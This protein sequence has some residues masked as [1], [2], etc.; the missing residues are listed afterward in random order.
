[1]SEPDADSSVEKALAGGALQHI[2]W[3]RF[4]FGDERWEWLDEVAVLHGTRDVVVI[5]ERLHDTSGE[6]IG[7]QGFYIDVTPTASRSCRW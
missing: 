7:T 1:V 3:Y 5:D 6:L 4:Y 2:G